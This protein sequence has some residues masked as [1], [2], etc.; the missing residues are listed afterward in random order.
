MQVQAGR[1][2]SRIDDRWL[3]EDEHPREWYKRFIVAGHERPYPSIQVT[4]SV[5]HGR[6]Q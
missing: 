3:H 4:Q 1:D 5:C 2:L 6:V